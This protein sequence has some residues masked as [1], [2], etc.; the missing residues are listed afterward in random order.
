M[1]KLFPTCPRHLM[2]DLSSDLKYIVNATANVIFNSRQVLIFIIY[3]VCDL[4]FSELAR[5]YPFITCIRQTTRHSF[6]SNA[7]HFSPQLCLLAV[8]CAASL[9]PGELPPQTNDA[10]EQDE[11]GKL[12]ADVSRNIYYRTFVD[13][14]ELLGQRL[15]TQLQVV[16]GQLNDEYSAKDFK[17]S[18]TI[19]GLGSSQQLPFLMPF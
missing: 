12:D 13:H 11:Q 1:T 18:T 8:A 19:W 9:S 16:L 5:C 7:E 3:I 2:R 10:A 17:V 4:Q 15:E 6:P 14:P